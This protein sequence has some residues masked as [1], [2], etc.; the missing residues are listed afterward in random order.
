MLEW[1]LASFKILQVENI[2]IFI[3]SASKVICI[4]R[5][6]NGRL[7][8]WKLT[9]HFTLDSNPKTRTQSKWLF[10]VFSRNSAELHL[11]VNQF[12]T[13]YLTGT[14]AFLSSRK[15]LWNRL[16]NCRNRLWW[17]Y[18]VVTSYLL[19]INQNVR[20]KDFFFSWIS[21]SSV[22]RL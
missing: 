11:I 3:H 19:I 5:I 2:D 14:I 16:P 1:P 22:F 6:H 17:L 15:Y 21:K 12:S 8:L 10:G 4:N 18:F 9:I 13:A 20:P 7:L